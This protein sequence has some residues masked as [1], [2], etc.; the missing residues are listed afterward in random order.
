MQTK[1]TILSGAPGSGK[2]TYATEEGAITV[3]S[4][5]IRMELCGRYD[6]FTQE[7]LVWNVFNNRI[8][9]VI[10]EVPNVILDA[11]FL[12]NKQRERYVKL[13]GDKVDEIEL[14]IFKKPLEVCLRQNKMRPRNKWV[15]D[16]IVEMMYC[17]C[18]EPNEYL[19]QKCNVIYIRE[20]N[21]KCY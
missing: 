9:E 5:D 17:R 14:V 2:S 19:K 8:C 16:D 20:E 6:D 10:G 4:D 21:E 13:Y 15:P 18:E 3:S 1:L 12:S 7:D 11:T